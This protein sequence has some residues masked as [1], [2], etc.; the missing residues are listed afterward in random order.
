MAGIGARS[1][2][3]EGKPLFRSVGVPRTGYRQIERSRSSLKD[4]GETPNE[5]SHYHRDR[6]GAILVVATFGNVLDH[7][8][9]RDGSSL[10]PPLPSAPFAFA[11][12][13]LR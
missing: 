6:L 3:P 7:I 12:A 2:I 9:A 8:A 13:L 11:T 5:P 10:Q 4:I 1:H